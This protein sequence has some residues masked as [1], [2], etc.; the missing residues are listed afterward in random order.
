MG[1]GTHGYYPYRVAALY[2]Q[3]WSAHGRLWELD[4]KRILIAAAEAVQ[5][6]LKTVDR[7]LLNH[8]DV[9][10]CGAAMEAVLGGK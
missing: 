10:R 2:H 9:R 3:F 4:R 8:A 1:Q 5:A 6:K 7:H